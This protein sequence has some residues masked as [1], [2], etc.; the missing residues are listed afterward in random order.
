MHNLPNAAYSEPG[1]TT[2]FLKSP[3]CWPFHPWSGPVCHSERIALSFWQ[4]WLRLVYPIQRCL[5]LNL[6]RYIKPV[7]NTKCSKCFHLATFVR[8]HFIDTSDKSTFSRA[9][10]QAEGTAGI[11]LFSHLD[12]AFRNGKIISGKPFGK[13]YPGSLFRRYLFFPSCQTGA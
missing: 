3:V 6:Q 11:R 5:R 1:G 7:R 8:P 13:G 2:F 10:K 9:F 12:K 4:K